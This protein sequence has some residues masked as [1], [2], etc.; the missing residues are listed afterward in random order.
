MLIQ[1]AAG[2]VFLTLVVEIGDERGWG[3]W[4]SVDMTMRTRWMSKLDGGGGVVVE[5][6][7]DSSGAPRSHRGR[8]SARSA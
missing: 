3:E 1:I 4:M 5:K 2:D 8:Y 6:C 7:C